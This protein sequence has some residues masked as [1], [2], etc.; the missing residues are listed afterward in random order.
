M[1]PRQKHQHEVPDDA[2]VH[3]LGHAVVGN[4]LGIAEGI[5]AF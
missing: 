1:T 2:I 3:E 4:E 5:D